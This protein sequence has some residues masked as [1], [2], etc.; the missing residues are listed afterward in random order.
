M[1]A[2]PE[3]QRSLAAGALVVL[4]MVVVGWWLIITKGDAVPAR[5]AAPGII[6]GSAM[7]GGPFTLVDHT[8]REVTEATFRG[9]Y[10]LVFF[11]FANCPDVCPLMRPAALLLLRILAF[12]RT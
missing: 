12:V 7:I 4:A 1:R 9:R 8:G 6:T 10:L 3:G 11:G 5:P 2:V